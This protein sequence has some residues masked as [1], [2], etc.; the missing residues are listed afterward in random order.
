MQCGDVIAEHWKSDPG[1]WNLWVLIKKKNTDA[2][3]ASFE[4]E[5]MESFTENV[6]PA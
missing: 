5:T 6:T 1:Q 3:L 4:L 2:Y